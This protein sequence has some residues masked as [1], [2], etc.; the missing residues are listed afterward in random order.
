MRG[1]DRSY[2]YNAKFK[3]GYPYATIIDV[4]MYLK[5]QGKKEMKIWQICQ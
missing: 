1:W 3:I 2:G 5:F 4:I